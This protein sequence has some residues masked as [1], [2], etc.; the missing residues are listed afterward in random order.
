[1]PNHTSGINILHLAQMWH[2]YRILISFF[3]RIDPDLNWIRDFSRCQGGSWSQH[4]AELVHVQS[5]PLCVMWIWWLVHGFCPHLNAVWDKTRP[6][7]VI[8]YST[9]PQW[10]C[11]AGQTLICVPKVSCRI[12]RFMWQVPC[13]VQ[14]NRLNHAMDNK[15]F[16]IYHI[17]FKYISQNN[18]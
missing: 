14:W 13:R 10:Q 12:S 2:R 1:M 15:A 8:A 7:T 17:S 3:G 6:V 5:S 9:Q 4:S 18:I 11:R 16:Q